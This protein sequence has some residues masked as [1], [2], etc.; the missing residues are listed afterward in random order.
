[1][2]GLG[3]PFKIFLLVGL[4]AVLRQRGQTRPTALL[5]AFLAVALLGSFA[6]I[7]TQ[8]DNWPFSAWPLV[9]A[10][11][12][13]NVTQ[14]RILAVDAHGVE[15]DVDFRAWR[16][17]DFGEL[18][19]WLQGP[20]QSLSLPQRQAVFAY[21]LERVE[22]TRLRARE[23]DLGGLGWLG[24]FEAPSFVLHPRRWNDPETTPAES[25][26]GLRLYRET[27]SPESRARGAS[28]S[29]RLVFEYASVRAER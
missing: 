6:P 26:V 2:S 27:W 21:L 7:F 14:E 13:R 12:P 17:F 1:M 5:H 11:A 29:R 15:H 20:F 28:P 19:S 22:G 23:G 10:T 25:F 24:P 9:A 8:R 16:P 18:F 3:L 4:L